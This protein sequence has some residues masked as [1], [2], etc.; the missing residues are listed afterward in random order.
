MRTKIGRNKTGCQY[1]KNEIINIKNL[2]S[3]FRRN[4]KHYA[5]S[6]DNRLLYKSKKTCYKK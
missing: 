1:N 5:L 3:E 4:V 6:D 2:K